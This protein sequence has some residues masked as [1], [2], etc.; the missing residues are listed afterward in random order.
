MIQ[1]IENIKKVFLIHG[2][3]ELK[4]LIKRLPKVLHFKELPDG[5]LKIFTKEGIFMVKFK[6]EKKVS[7]IGEKLRELGEFVQTHE[8]G[9]NDEIGHHIPDFEFTGLFLGYLPTKEGKKDVV[10]FVD[11]DG[12]VK[13]IAV[14]QIYG[15]I[16]YRIK[17]EVIDQFDIVYIKYKGKVKID[18]A[19]TKNVYDVHVYSG[20]ENSEYVKNVLKKADLDE[21]IVN[22]FKKVM[23]EIRNETKDS[24][25]VSNEVE[26]D[27]PP[28]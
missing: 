11:P 5:S 12:Q 10:Y 26:N 17:A 13:K 16:K 2:I 22:F 23:E 9:E 4:I 8:R 25:I 14:F 7:R 1:N 24:E 19:K 3:N 21:D 18:K 15:D 20:T 27:E 28:F 6:G